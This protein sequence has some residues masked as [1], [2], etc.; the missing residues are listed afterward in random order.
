MENQNYSLTEVHDFRTLL[1]PDHN[2]YCAGES[3][4]LIQV[5]ETSAKAVHTPMWYLE[6]RSL[7][8]VKSIVPFIITKLSWKFPKNLL[9][10][11]E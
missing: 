11:F 4:F 10:V 9:Q 7:P 6:S 1:V 2:T 5:V 3:P 8:Q